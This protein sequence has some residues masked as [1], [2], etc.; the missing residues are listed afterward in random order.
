M[1]QANANA[2]QRLLLVEDEPELLQILSQHFADSGY[3][4]EVA[5]NGAE[6]LRRVIGSDFDVIVC[7][8]VLP[9]LP[10]NMFYYAVQRVKPGLCDRFVF[11]TGHGESPDVREFLTSMSERVIAKPF[12]L[13]DLDSAVR[14]VAGGSGPAARPIEV[15]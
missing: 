7:D 2:R 13:E 4:V 1:D 3:A 14:D 10:G 12:N 11:I 5:A 6:A 9:R 15:T 8:M